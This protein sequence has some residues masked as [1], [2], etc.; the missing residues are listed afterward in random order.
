MLVLCTFMCVYNYP[1]GLVMKCV[2][3]LVEWVR[4][5]LTAL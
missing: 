3:D 4:S 1:W 2:M 5:Y